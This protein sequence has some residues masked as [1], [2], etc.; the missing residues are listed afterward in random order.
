MADHEFFGTVSGEAATA[1]DHFV[2][3]SQLDSGVA[4][5]SDLSNATGNLPTSQI[6]NFSSEV[7]ALIEAIVN[8]EGAAEALDTLAELAAALGNDPDFAGTVTTQLGDLDSRLDSLEAGAGT[9]TFKQDVGDATVSTFT[10]THNLGTQDV[11]VDVTRKSDFQKV[12]PVIKAPTANTVTVDFGTTVPDVN[13]FRV[14]VD[15]K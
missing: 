3:K 8:A 15:G 13:A 14:I 2:Q 12:F 11:L 10:I 9:S 7:N 4:L 5:A 1:S 6:T